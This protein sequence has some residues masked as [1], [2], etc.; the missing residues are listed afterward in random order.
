MEKKYY[1]VTMNLAFHNAVKQIY[2]ELFCD[3]NY[4]N[5]W[6]QLASQNNNKNLPYLVKIGMQ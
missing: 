2:I 4:Y 3:L 5:L 1:I 6:Q